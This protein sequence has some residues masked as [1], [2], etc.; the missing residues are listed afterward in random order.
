[1]DIANR[2]TMTSGG[3]NVFFHA[4]R[5]VANRQAVGVKSEVTGRRRR[6]AMLAIALLVER[7]VQL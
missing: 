4:Y 1:M 6:E 3:G 7:I 5:G 2:R